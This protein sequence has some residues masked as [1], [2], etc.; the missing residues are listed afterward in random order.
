MQMQ[1][2]SNANAMQV[3]KVCY[4]NAMQNYANKNKNKNK[5]KEKYKYKN[6]RSQSVCLKADG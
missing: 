2:N 3:H 1:C 5:T 6:I 4:A